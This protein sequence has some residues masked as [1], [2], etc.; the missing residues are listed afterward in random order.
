[1]ILRAWRGYAADGRADEYPRHLLESVLPKLEKVAG[2]RGLYLLRR[3][4]GGEV[5]YRVLTIWESVD[6]ITAFAGA[7]PERAVVEP[8][9]QAV[10]NHYDVEVQHYEVLAHPAVLGAP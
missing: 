10:L 6:A 4:V 8:Q 5:E 3:P 2:F 1:M 7:T 9:A